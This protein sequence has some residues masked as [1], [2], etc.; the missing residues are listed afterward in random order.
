MK[1][2]RCH[3][4]KVKKKAK[5]VQW[6]IESCHCPAAGQGLEFKASLTEVRS[7]Q[8]YYSAEV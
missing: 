6:P 7:G 1:A 2:G 4:F 8:V 5:A 3:V